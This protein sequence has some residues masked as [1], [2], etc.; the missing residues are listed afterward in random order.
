MTLSRLHVVVALALGCGHAP[1]KQDM[2]ETCQPAPGNGIVVVEVRDADSGAPV[3]DAL[4]LLGCDGGR[5][6]RETYPDPQGLVR[7]RDVP[8]GVCTI[9][10]YYRNTRG[11]LLACV[12][13]NRVNRAPLELH[14]R[15]TR[16]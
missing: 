5:V 13:A 2:A 6:V 3:P 7:F 15:A 8:T 14:G 16:Y 12:K 9:Q 10:G 4:V 1:A 11:G